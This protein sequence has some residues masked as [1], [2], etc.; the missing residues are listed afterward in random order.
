MPIFQIS[1]K[2]LIPVEQTNFITEK[3]LQSLI[4]ANL[5]PF[6]TAGLWRQSFQPGHSMLGESTLWL[7]QK[8]TTR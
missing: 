2:K 6:L 8:T 3:E 5:A 4:E 7:C 1:D